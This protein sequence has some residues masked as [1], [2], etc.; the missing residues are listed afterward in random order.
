[1]VLAGFPD[2]SILLLFLFVIGKSSRNS[3]YTLTEIYLEVQ[4]TIDWSEFLT[5]KPVLGLDPV[6]GMAKSGCD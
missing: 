2:N 6:N 5:D 1:M 4:F 3:Y